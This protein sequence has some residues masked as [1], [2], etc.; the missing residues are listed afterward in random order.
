MD[1]VGPPWGPVRWI[2][3]RD[4]AMNEEL[5][6]PLMSAWP[7]EDQDQ[8]QLPPT[9]TATS[10]LPP[11]THSLHLGTCRKLRWTVPFTLA[12]RVKRPPKR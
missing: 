11:E 5:S 8:P 7:P 4:L 9:L 12:W 3:D 2:Q 10:S 6:E 1:C